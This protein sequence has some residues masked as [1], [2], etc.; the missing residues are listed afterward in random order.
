MEVRFPGSM[1]PFPK[2]EF[3]EFFL[4]FDSDDDPASGMKIFDASSQAKH[5]AVLSFSE[6]AHPS[7]TPPII[8]AGDRFQNRDV[9]LM[10]NAAFR[11]PFDV[12]HFRR[13]HQPI[14]SRAMSFLR[15]T[16]FW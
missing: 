1:T 4:Y 5:A 15:M 13:G 8:L 6:S 7:M 3:G 11:P 16:R 14:R 12:T 9:C 10:Q 2:L